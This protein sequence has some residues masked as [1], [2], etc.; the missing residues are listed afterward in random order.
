MQIHAPSLFYTWA[1]NV[2]RQDIF[3]VIWWN[4]QA[5]YQKQLRGWRMIPYI[6]QKNT[7]WNF[8]HSNVF[9]FKTQRIRIG[10]HPQQAWDSG[11]KWCR[12]D[13]KP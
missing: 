13:Q 12:I 3:S 4:F 7:H 8:K 9:Y 1:Q 2:G 10:K 11:T 6:V 5:V